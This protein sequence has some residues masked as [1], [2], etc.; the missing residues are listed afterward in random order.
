MTHINSII[1]L[2][3]NYELMA[4]Y[5]KHTLNL[6]TYKYS[7]PVSKELYRTMEN[8]KTSYYS[9]ELGKWCKD[10]NLAYWFGKGDKYGVTVNYE[11]DEESVDFQTTEELDKK[12]ESLNDTYM[13]WVDIDE[14]SDYIDSLSSE[15]K[16]LLQ[17]KRD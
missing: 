5:R 10:N 15:Q 6:K 7:V 13:Q 16:P 8:Q 9:T 3:K 11:T 2:K 14:D 12:I 4:H 1:E 17:K